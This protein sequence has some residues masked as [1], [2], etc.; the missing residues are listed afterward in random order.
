MFEQINSQFVSAAKQFADSAL[1]A[2]SL[3][4]E[5]VE[6]LVG[7]QIRTVE[8][9]A[10]ATAAFLSEAAEVRDFDGAKAIWPK[11]INLARESAE[12][13]YGASQEAFGQTLKTSEAIGALV[14]G[15]IDAASAHVAQTAKPA[16]A[17]K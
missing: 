6:R 8:A 3:A 7:L 17:A 16:K 1:K 2:N 4:L 12:A 5:N 13:C 15:H 9:Q 14:K 10:N 11:G